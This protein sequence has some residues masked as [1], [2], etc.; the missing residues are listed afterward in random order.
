ML[1]LGRSKLH[2]RNA[3]RTT[4]I[5]AAVLVS[6]RVVLRGCV[7]SA[8]SAVSVSDVLGPIDAAYS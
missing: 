1:P 7:Q 2:P 4:R 8:M 5:A 6:H 3:P